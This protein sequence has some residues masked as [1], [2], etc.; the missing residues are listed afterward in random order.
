MKSELQFKELEANVKNVFLAAEAARALGL[1]PVNKVEIP[2][3]TSLAEKV[4]GLISVRYP[5]IQDKKIINRILELEGEYG[6]L[7][8]AVAFKIAE[9]I[10]KEKFCK[11]SSLLEGIDAGIRVGF[12]YG[13]LSVVSSPLE[14]FTELK[15]NKTE[16]NEDYFAAYFSG[17]IRSAGTTAS[18]VVLMLIDY[19]RETFGYAKYDPNEKEVKR[20]VTENYD[21]HERVNNLQYLPTE[22][23]IA[24]LAENLPIQITGEPSVSKEVSNYKDIA[25]VETNFIRG[26]MCLIFSEGLAQKAQKGLRILRALQAKGF[27]ISD[28]EFLEK[29]VALHKKR[30]KGTT[31]TTPSYIKD[32]VAGRPV[33]GYPSRS[34]AF[35]FRYGRSR[36][37]GFSAM[38][39]HPATMAITDNFLSIGAQL[40]VEKPTKGCALT[41]CDSIDGPIVKLNNGS[42]RKIQNLDEA[43]KIYKDV[44]EI[45]YLGDLLVPIGDVINRN[46]ELIK[47]GY[48]EE[49]W[50]LEVRKKSEGKEALDKEISF[51]RALEIS[52]RHGVPLYPKFIYYWSQISMDDF[53]SLLDWTAN[54]S[55]A[56][57]IILPYSKTEQERYKRGKRAL[58]IIGAEHEVTIE[59]VVLSEETSWAFLANLGVDIN[60][61]SKKTFAEI[62]EEISLKIKGEEE[63]LK[64]I[65]KVS[66][67]VICDKAGTFIGARMGRPE[68]AKLRKLVGS[69]NVLFPVGSE[70][71]RLRSVNEAVSVGSVRAEFPLYFCKECKKENI[72]F[73]CA[74]CSKECN[75]LNFCRQCNSVI[76]EGKCPEHGKSTTFYYKT[77]DMKEIFKNAVKSI[78]FSNGEAPVLIKGVKGTSNEGHIVE[79]LAKGILRAKHILAVNKDGTI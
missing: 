5:Q 44:R 78:G 30:E 51:D 40:K 34:G 54:A 68:K 22:E 47:P 17:P 75:L 60:K 55:F 38:S 18:C 11:F 1:D 2:L 61:L 26:G 29:Y 9:E 12:A 31:D 71:G 33:F 72:Y 46:Y 27:K 49:W 8:P 69:P 65:S 62:V 3:A 42:V 21:Y 76:G 20:Y 15:L 41:A 6:P 36:S 52:T 45:I 37:G 66:N 24:F 35:R 48:V 50:R 77:V 67:F 13:T 25:R 10:A 28:W 53:F 74:T 79:N 57:K 39:V 4:V 64:A 73:K 32:I 63:V 59:N 14:G 70:G 23:E 58:E 16:K 7:D 43:K 19:L 56:G